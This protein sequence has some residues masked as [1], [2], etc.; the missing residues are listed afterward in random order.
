[1]VKI[2]TP[3]WLKPVSTLLTMYANSF[4]NI[5]LFSPQ[6]KLGDVVPNFEADTTE[7]FINFH[8]WIGDSWAILFS[9]PADYTPGM[10]NKTENDFS[11]QAMSKISM[12]DKNIH[13]IFIC[14]N[15][16]KIIASKDNYQAN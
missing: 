15:T 8:E 3:E 4:S 11:P 9:H 2:V 1:M 5:R 10:K 6:C 12:V 7:G 16:Y 13:M 14:S